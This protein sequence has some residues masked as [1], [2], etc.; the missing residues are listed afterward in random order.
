[1]DP[2]KKGATCKSARQTKPIQR[3]KKDR[4]IKRR[5]RT[6]IR[7]RAQQKRRE[8]KTQQ[9]NNRKNKPQMKETGAWEEKIH[10]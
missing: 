7:E 2:T 6:T 8:G 9:Q 4:Y 3:Q 5:T 10:K 1:M